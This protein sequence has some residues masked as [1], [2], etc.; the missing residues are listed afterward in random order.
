ME[1]N[2]STAPDVHTCPACGNTNRELMMAGFDPLAGP[3]PDYGG[4][5]SLTCLRWL[6]KDARCW[7]LWFPFDLRGD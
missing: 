2:V 1:P 3:A 7:H 6:S 5:L 4:S